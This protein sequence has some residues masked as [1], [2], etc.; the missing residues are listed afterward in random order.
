MKNDIVASQNNEKIAVKT[1]KQ[2]WMPVPSLHCTIGFTSTE[3]S[4]YIMLS[5]VPLSFIKSIFSTQ[6]HLQNSYKKY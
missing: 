3:H 2:N 1:R 5:H 4:A 6:T